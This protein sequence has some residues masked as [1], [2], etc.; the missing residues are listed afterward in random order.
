MQLLDGAWFVEQRCP[1][2]A[3]AGVR[4]T[5]SACANTRDLRRGRAACWAVTACAGESSTASATRRS[6]R[7]RWTGAVAK[8]EAGWPM[9]PLALS[10]A[11]SARPGGARHA[12]AIRRCRIA[13]QAMPAAMQEERP[14]AVPGRH[15]ARGR[16][17]ELERGNLHVDGASGIPRQRRRARNEQQRR[18]RPHAVRASRRGRFRPGPEATPIDS[19]IAAPVARSSRHLVGGSMLI[20]SMPAR[21]G[22]AVSQIEPARKAAIMAPRWRRI[23]V[24]GS[25]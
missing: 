1:P 7:C 21:A 11:W 24:A 3:S 2:R 8:A 4:E 6:G 5:A 10:G 23:S 25:A 15:P 22:M 17:P 19:D 16:A 20:S 14:V 12:R 13:R 18:C 9:R